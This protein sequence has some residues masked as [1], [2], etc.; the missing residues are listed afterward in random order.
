MPMLKDR[1]GFK[2]VLEN[3]TSEQRQPAPEV[4]YRLTWLE[5]QR[6]GGKQA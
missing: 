4:D 5:N 1:G 6:K 2:F 3:V